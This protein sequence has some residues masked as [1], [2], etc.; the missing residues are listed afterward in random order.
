M[1]T[2]RKLANCYV[3]LN[4]GQENSGSVP[5]Q[6]YNIG[7]GIHLMVL[8]RKL[9]IREVFQGHIAKQVTFGLQTMTFDFKNLYFSSLGQSERYAC[10][11]KSIELYRIILG[12]EQSQS[13][14]G[15]K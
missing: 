8:I 10:S 5:Q 1:T 4:T 12:S 6:P 11:F 9:R 15:V 14:G 7:V 2:G 13:L 3:V